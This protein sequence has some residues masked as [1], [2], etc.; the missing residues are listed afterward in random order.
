MFKKQGISG[1]L[2]SQTR[3]RVR[4]IVNNRFACGTFESHFRNRFHKEA[5]K[6]QVILRCSLC[7]LWLSAGGPLAGGGGVQ[8]Q[9]GAHALLPGALFSLAFFD[10][11]PDAG[12]G[13]TSELTHLHVEQCRHD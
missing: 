13:F 5:Q 9:A 3:M 4:E 8:A 10:L 7:F 1:V 2:R 11:R 12:E 6:S